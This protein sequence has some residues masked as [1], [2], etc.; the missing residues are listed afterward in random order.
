MFDNIFAFLKKIKVPDIPFS[1]FWRTS[2]VV[3]IDVGVHSVKVAEVDSEGGRAVLKT[4]GELL[5]KSYLKDG[6][7]AGGGFLHYHDDETLQILPEVLRAS[8][9]KAKDAEGIP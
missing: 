7:G 3:G 6:A 1:F 2:R 4:Y 9:V 5:A 8:S